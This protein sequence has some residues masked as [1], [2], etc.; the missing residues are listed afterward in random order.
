MEIERDSAR[1][2]RA[3]HG[4]ERILRGKTAQH[5]GKDSARQNRAAQGKGFCAAKPRSTG[6]R[7]LRGKTAQHRG[8]IDG[9]Y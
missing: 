7:I 6:G 9:K 8:W 4:E 3:A 5:R 2:N 1:Q